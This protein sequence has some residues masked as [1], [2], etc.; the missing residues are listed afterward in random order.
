MSRLYP[1]VYCTEDGYCKKYSDDEVTSWCVQGPCKDEKP[2]NA[3]RIRAMTDEE[4]ANLFA[5]SDCHECILDWH[6][7]C[8]SANGECGRERVLYWLKQEASE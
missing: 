4:L 5:T 6:D 2:S 8:K 7:A 1:C 3:D